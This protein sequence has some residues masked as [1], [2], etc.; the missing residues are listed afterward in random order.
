VRF[1]QAGDLANVITSLRHAIN[2]RPRDLALRRQLVQAYL[3]RRL[4]GAAL[5]ET[6]RA[7]LLTPGDSPEDAALQ[8]LRGDC[9]LAQVDVPGAL[10]AYREAMRLSPSDIVAQVALGDALMADNQFAEALKV[11][12][13]A[14]QTDSKS[15]LP[16]RRLARAAAGRAGS[17]IKEYATSL[18][19]VEQAR[20]LTPAADTE[21]YLEDYVA[22]IRLM[23]ARMRDFINEIQA[24]YQAKIQG[25]QT[26][27]Q[28]I[29]AAQD[30]KERA[31][32]LADYLDKLPPALGQDATHARYQ[33]GGAITLLAVSLLQEWL[34]SGETRVEESLKGAQAD[35]LR[36]LT[37]ARKR[38]DA[39]RQKR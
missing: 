1:R 32:A 4:V 9:L 34:M 7:L 33:Q 25:K 14:A 17:D 38:L 12:E 5:A 22:L 23:E 10:K 18:K 15:P 28:L 20:K 39:V 19:E 21:T 35:A 31:S 6:D 11:Y 27:D 36:E 16:H 24:N 37:T 3:D 26:N 29:R 30:L 8:R 13:T 2:D